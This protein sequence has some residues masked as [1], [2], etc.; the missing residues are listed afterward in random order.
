MIYFIL[1][2]TET[3]VQQKEKYLCAVN[4]AAAMFFFFSHLLDQLSDLIISLLDYFSCIITQL[5][6]L[7]IFYLPQNDSFSDTTYNGK[8]KNTSGRYLSIQMNKLKEKKSFA[9]LS[10]W[11]AQ[12][13]QK[14]FIVY[15]VE[16]TKHGI[17][18]AFFRFYLNT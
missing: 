13:I 15:F 2:F 11:K 14:A 10:F 12:K 5:T 9:R 17:V 8:I 18:F 7:I 16:I 3:N 1:Y 4:Y 6:G